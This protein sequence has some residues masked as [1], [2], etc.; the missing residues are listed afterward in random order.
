MLYS[1]L[2]P[3]HPTL[4][5]V[6][7]GAQKQVE[8]PLP[9]IVIAGNGLGGLSAAKELHRCLGS[10][11]LDSKFPG[12]KVT[13][14][15]ETS[16]YVFKPLL[17][18][19]F[20]SGVSASLPMKC[21]MPRRQKNITQK[22]SFAFRKAKIKSIDPTQHQVK[23][24]RG[25]F[26]Y[27]YLVVALGQVKPDPGKIPGLA[28]KGF[29]LDSPKDIQQIRDNVD[30]RLLEAL[31]NGLSMRAPSQEP[32][33]LRAIDQGELLLN[34]SSNQKKNLSFFVL[35]GGPTGV[36]AA[37][38]LNE[39]VQKRWKELIASKDPKTLSPGLSPK[40]SILHGGPTLL[41]GPVFEPIRK[42]MST[43]LA[44]AGIEIYLNH[45]VLAL[46]PEGLRV[47]NIHTG[48]TKLFE[49]VAPIS[50]LG[51]VPNPV[52]SAFAPLGER[53]PVNPFLQV[54]NA[55]D[56]YVIGD[57]AAAK[58]SKNNPLP[59]LGQVAF[60]QGQYVAQDIVQ[61]LGAR[62]LA[63]SHSAT[64]PT[65]VTGASSLKRNP[66][67]YHHKGVSLAAGT[68]D[69]VFH[70]KLPLGLGFNFSGRLASWVRYWFY[71]YKMHQVEM[72]S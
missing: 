55:P 6:S 14:I 50:C 11:N 7:F 20:Q 71:E 51:G 72:R 40:V 37:L 58:D 10:K 1:S 4:S 61:R 48:E 21:I 18:D 67:V 69:A 34:A 15:G 64:G 44:Q 19:G 13:V 47:K 56:V 39:Y 25:T 2:K 24:S 66:F 8:K 33:S 3:S 32:H 41:S 31:A 38:F 70:V 29:I 63:S 53:V 35:G 57:V 43:K 12:A 30:H 62:A 65:S 54:P 9:Q 59:G 16:D 49:T 52:V 36:E 60:Q 68:Q 46:D 22:S 42:A 27:D 45:Q 26:H 17:L 28:E 23:T 5:S